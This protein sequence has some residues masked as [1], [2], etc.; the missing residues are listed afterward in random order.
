MNEQRERALLLT[1]GNVDKHVAAIAAT[2][3]E[4][5]DVWHEYFRHLEAALAL[6]ADGVAPPLNEPD[7]DPPKSTPGVPGILE[8]MADQITTLEGR[9]GQLKATVDRLAG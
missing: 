9:V 6:I 7:S 5:A 1:I 3:V 4:E 2:L 8:E